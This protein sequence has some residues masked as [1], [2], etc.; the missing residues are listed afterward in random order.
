MET[1]GRSPAEGPTGVPRSLPTEAA[2]G[3]SVRGGQATV[4]GGR[5]GAA[6][7]RETGRDS[8]SG[9]DREGPGAGVRPIARGVTVIEVKRSFRAHSVGPQGFTRS[10][11]AAVARS[12][13]TA[14]RPTG[15]SSAPRPTGTT[16]S[17][18]E[19]ECHRPAGSLRLP[20]H[21]FGWR[22]DRDMADVGGVRQWDLASDVLHRSMWRIEF[23][24]A[25]YAWRMRLRPEACCMS[26][27]PWEPATI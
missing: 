3:G 13:P 20:Y 24:P 8:L 10:A 18:L 25:R 1:N 12:R 7:T 19:G 6:E 4:R 16:P 23:P 14:M 17:P 27:G 9:G 2:R 22:V 21:L 26:R 15:S 11:T 5:S